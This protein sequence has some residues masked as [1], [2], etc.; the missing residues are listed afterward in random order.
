M[1]WSALLV[2]GVAL[3]ALPASAVCYRHPFGNPD[4]ADG[5]GS[6]CCGRT[7]P[8][9]G[10]DY[11][12]AA[13]TPIPVIADGVV[14]L[15]TSSS[16]LGNVVVVRHDDG[17]FSGYSHMLSGSPVPEGTRVTMGQIIGRVGNTGSCSFGAHLHLTIAPTLGGYASGTTSDPNA[18]INARTQCGPP[19]CDRTAGLFTFSCD[20]AQSG[21]SC[22]NLDEPADPH[23]WADN[24]LCTATNWGIRWSSAG[25]IAG[26]T[27]TNIA[28][29]AE[30]LAAAWSDDYLCVPPQS[31]IALSWSSAGPLAGQTCVNFNE[32]AD[33]ANSWGDNYLCYAQVGR[34]STDDFTFSSAGS[35]SGMTCE[36]VNEPADP[37]TWA[38][39]LFCS[40]PALQLGM[41]WSSAGPI[42]GMDCEN[43]AEPAEHAAAAWSDNFLCLPPQ[44]PFGLSWHSAG[45][46]AGQSCVRW[47]EWSD[48]GGSWGD[49]FMCSVPLHD[50]SQGGLT[51]SADG[52]N[53][54]QHCVSV[55]EPLDPNG[56][57][58]NHLCTSLEL[59]MT[60]SSQGALEGLDCTAIT[61]PGET[62][63]GW[64]DNHLCLPRGATHAL[65]W[66]THGPLAG[67][68]CVR[69]YEADDLAAGW[70]SNYLCARFLPPE[71]RTLVLTQTLLRPPVANPAP[72]PGDAPNDPTRIVGGVGCRGVDGLFLLASLALLR[73]RRRD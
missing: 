20:G 18:F 42:A 43:I 14:A 1:R 66:S 13:G 47:F 15:R 28:E 6:T 65:T 10:L 58:D 31:P 17:M 69:W 59:P 30:P 68:Q 19:P 71:E 35:V 37:N 3:W 33:L 53:A 49:N 25:P 40:R 34:F 45:P 12:Q 32:T 7:N 29:P 60:W 39:N 22:V 48:L 55:D 11:P 4:L 24:F 70:P 26:M 21:Q 62:H 2:F 23:T 50:F 63:P 5:W 9:R 61:A 16:C 64:N 56:W 8:H 72:T 52:P 27:C 38:D 36:S 41:K 57:S 44:S 73:C 54:G 46:L 51:F 67:Q